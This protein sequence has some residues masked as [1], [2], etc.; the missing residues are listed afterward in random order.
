MTK[1]IWLLA[2]PYVVQVS[3]TGFD[4][5]DVESQA[6]YL[7]EVTSRFGFSCR[8]DSKDFCYDM[9]EA[10]NSAHE[11]RMKR[12]Q[13]LCWDGKEKVPCLP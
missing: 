7:L 6:H 11:R 1:W 9:A 13:L 2:V 12:Q 8:E 10:L 4:R 3:S 5:D